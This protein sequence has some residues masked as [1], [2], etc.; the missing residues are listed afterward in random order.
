MA[1]IDEQNPVQSPAPGNGSTGNCFADLAIT[2]YQEQ[3]DISGQPII[4]DGTESAREA[5]CFRSMVQ[6]EITGACDS[7]EVH[8]TSKISSEEARCL[9]RAMAKLY[10]EEEYKGDM[11]RVARVCGGSLYLYV[12]KLGYW[13]RFKPDELE[14]AAYKLEGHP[15]PSTKKKQEFEFI[16]MNDGDAKSVAKMMLKVEFGESDDPRLPSTSP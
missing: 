8:L 11:S 1:T 13:R 15:Y 5:A 12:K 9:L 16:K 10:S 4:T 2:D 3:S 7:Q 6:D 14:A